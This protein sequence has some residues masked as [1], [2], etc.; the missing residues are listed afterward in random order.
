[1]STCNRHFYQ[2]VEAFSVLGI[3]VLN[4][5]DPPSL[6]AGGGH[7]VVLAG[8]VDVGAVRDIVVFGLRVRGRAVDVGQTAVD[9]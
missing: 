5:R 8:G 3:S 6:V 7:H 4:G 1:M 9:A 2:I